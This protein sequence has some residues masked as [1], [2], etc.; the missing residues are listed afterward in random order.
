MSHEYDL[1]LQT[2]LNNEGM[3]EAHLHHSVA[4]YFKVKS[5]IY[6]EASWLERH[7]VAAYVVL[8]VQFLQMVLAFTVHPRVAMLTSTVQ[9]ALY[10]M[11]HFFFVFAILFLMLAFMANFLLG[12][13]IHIFGTF[14][15]ACSA[16]VRMLFGEFIYADGVEV[17]SGT[18]LVMYWLYAVSFMLIVFFTLLN[19]FL[20]IIVDAFVEVKD[21]CSQLRCTQSFFEDLCSMAGTLYLQRRYKLPASKRLVKFLSESLKGFEAVPKGSESE[22]KPPLFSAEA[23]R[24]E[25][26]LEESAVCHWL[27]RIESMSSVPLVHVQYPDDV[28]DEEPPKP[29]PD[30][31]KEVVEVQVGHDAN[32]A[33]IEPITHI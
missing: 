3:D 30:E 12:G 10:N 14:G 4:E 33:N 1:L 8:Y 26:G 27:C 7:R 19:F 11:M 2:F 32:I 5:V 17:L 21:N 16:Q 23:I 22:G 29:A 18:A 13:R 15:S 31:T 25:F 20:A 9:K 24:S 28:D 6:E